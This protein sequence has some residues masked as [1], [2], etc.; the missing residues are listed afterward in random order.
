MPN[1]KY[2]SDIYKEIID[3]AS[4][5]VRFDPT[6]LRDLLCLDLSDLEKL[7]DKQ[8]GK[9]LIFKNHYKFD[10][11]DLT[12][13]LLVHT[14]L[15]ADSYWS[16]CKENILTLKFYQLGDNFIFHNFHDKNK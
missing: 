7:S 8:V 2:D 16:H 9:E 14:P 4:R 11:R 1:L 6:F 5:L 10:T 13:I 12:N 3:N 15:E